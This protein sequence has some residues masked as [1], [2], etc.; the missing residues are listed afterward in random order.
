[1]HLDLLESILEVIAPM[2][3]SLKKSFDYL[4]KAEKLIPSLTQTFSKA[5]YTFV[6][7][8]YPVYADRGRGSKIIDVDGNE[9]IDYLCG[10]GPV[11]LGYCYPAVDDAV[12]RQLEK[13][14]TFSLPHPLEIEVAEALE[15]T[16]PCAEM[17]KYSKTGSDAVTAAARGARAITKRDVI[18][19]CG[20]GGVWHDWYTAIT[21][22]DYGV[23]KSAKEDIVTFEYNKIET[24]KRIFEEKPDKIAAV[25]MEATMFEPPRDNFL[26]QVKDLAHKN[27]AVL[28]FD[29]IVTGFRFAVGGGQERYGVEP[30]IATLGKGMSNGMPIGAVV[31]KSEYMHIFDDVFFSTTFAGETLSLAASLATINEIEDKNVPDYIWKLGTRLMD[32]Y[33]AIAREKNL[34]SVVSCIGY[35]VRMRI[36]CKDSTGND[37]LLIKSLLLQEMVK[38]GIFIQPSVQ[39]ISYSHTEEDVQ[40]TLEAFN[41]S[42]NIVGKALGEGNVQK[43]LEGE[44]ARP[45]FPPSK[46]DSTAA[47]TTTTSAATSSRR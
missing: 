14:M 37:S 32:G 10:L 16:V 20:T 5:P 41:E 43:Y 28:I 46:P 42:L 39:Y 24:L 9:Y 44:P 27:G 17:A 34:D 15:R 3:R 26:Q 36:L 31:G 13:G 22:R 18:A 2:P 29:E 21:T 12:K 8:V 11:V 6:K 25:C 40:K 30:D 23:P 33:N 38:Q 45:V 47:A 35:P 4:G 7:G 19:Y 1:M